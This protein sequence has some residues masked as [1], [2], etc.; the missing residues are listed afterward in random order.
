MISGVGIDLVEI[1]RIERIIERWGDRFVER[2]FSPGEIGYCLHKSGPARHFAAR[3][4]VKE[5]FFKSFYNWPGVSFSFRD[6]EV[7][8]DDAGRPLLRLHGELEKY[9]SSRNF[10]FH[11]SITHTEGF[12]AAV[13]VAER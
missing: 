8:S 10:K 5:A 9:A 13:V 6:I 1:K 11:I 7:M 4:A 3:F 2:I 12:A